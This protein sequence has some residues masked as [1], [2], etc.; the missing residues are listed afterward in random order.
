MIRVTTSPAVSLQKAA[1]IPRPPVQGVHLVSRKLEDAGHE[2]VKLYRGDGY[3]YFIYDKGGDVIVYESYSIMVMHFRTYSVAQWV[4]M[5][6]EFAIAV[7]DGNWDAAN[8][9]IKDDQG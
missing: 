5:G 1:R 4:A 9:R 7:Q 3:H 2:E 8:G 6:I